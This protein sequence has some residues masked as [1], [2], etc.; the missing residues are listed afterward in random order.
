MPDAPSPLD[1]G[2]AEFTAKLIA[3]VF[4][5]V[6][7]SSADQEQ[8]HADIVKAASLTAEEYA[9]R[10]VTPEQ[11]EKELARLF[12]AGQAGRAHAV[13]AGAPY[14]PQGRSG[15]E[16]PPVAATLGLKLKTGDFA[17]TPDGRFELTA[18]GADKIRAASSL[19]LAEASLAGLQR[20][21]ARGVQRVVVD[22]G[23]VNAKLTFQVVQTDDARVDTGIHLATPLKPLGDLPGISL[24]QA[25]SNVRLVVRQADLRNAGAGPEQVNVVGEIEIT[26][27]TIA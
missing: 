4:E 23:R 27:K 21:V 14:R 20:L 13:L 9:S 6:A 7:A 3:E 16:E 24:P 8:R 25:L 11:T 1:M 15:A 18:A 5:A 10:M 2:F 17:A 22:S 19:R 26:F 12:P